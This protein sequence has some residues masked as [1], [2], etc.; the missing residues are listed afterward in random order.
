MQKYN[1]DNIFYKI[2]NK[3]VKANIVLEGEHF[4]AFHDIAPKA[5]V[6]VLIIPKG[7][8]VDYNDFALN[9]S[10]EEILDLNKGISE[11]VKIMKLEKYGFKI[12]SNAGKFTTHEFPEPQSVMHMHIHILGKS[13]EE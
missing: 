9:A 1:K 3:E 8:Y 4:I 11:V 12:I 6:H 7:M 13:E 10:D 5:P 2:I